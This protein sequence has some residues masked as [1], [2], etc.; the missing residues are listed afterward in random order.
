[1]VANSAASHRIRGQAALS[2]ALVA[3]D[4]AIADLTPL[5]AAEKF[6]LREAAIKAFARIKSSAIA[7]PLRARL[8]VEP[9]AF[10]KED[11]Q[12]ILTGLSDKATPA[13]AGA[14]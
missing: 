2:L 5:L 14:K 7:D 10:L 8:S 13:A 9:K 6:R 3:G 4:A 12:K 1:M 11:I